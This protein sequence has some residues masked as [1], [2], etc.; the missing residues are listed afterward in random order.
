ELLQATHAG[1]QR[2]RLLLQEWLSHRQLADLRL[3]L[4]TRG[5]M[6]VIAEETP[7]LVAASVWGLV[8]SAQSEHPGRFQLLD[9][10]PASG[11]AELPWSALLA[12]D[13]P[14]LALRQSVVH[15]PRL[16]WASLPS[17]STELTAESHGTVLI[18]GGTGGLGAL[19]ARHLAGEHRAPHLLLVSRRG[20]RAE[21]ARELVSEL[22]GLGCAASIA[23]CD[24]SD[25]DALSRLIDEIPPDRPLR[26]VI[27]TAGVVEDGLIDAL[28]HD[29][30]E[31]V[32]RPKVDAALHLEDLTEDMQLTDFVLFSSAASAIGSP[33]QSN[34]AAANAFM[35]ALALRR[36]ARG[37]AATS[38]AWGMW[39]EGVGMTGDL[40]QSSMARLRR[41][42]VAG[43]SAEEGFR[44]LDLARSS[45]E[46][47]LMPARLDME[48]LPA[49]LRTVV[50][51]PA[52]RSRGGASSL[53][54]RLSELPES[55]RGAVV[56][57]L[58]RDHV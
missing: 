24:V 12:L 58:V 6:A 16:Q 25:R 2:M 31:R 5:A 54:Q 39:A 27:H 21:G 47:L 8:R 26:A 45:G 29:Q 19:V 4:V 3:V 57:Q 48:T 34:Y 50:G 18:T 33:G 46:P 14:Q 23:E 37:L 9:L 32:M 56:L 43:L 17:P 28:G 20:A 35:D 42:G 22:A 40:D 11:G 52:R 38:L 49:L 36:R 15:V 10:D 1:V 30:L 41:L 13:E 53:A 7:E 44:L 55:E 51:A